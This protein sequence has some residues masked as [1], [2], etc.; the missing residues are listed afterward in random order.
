MDKVQ[1]SLDGFQKSLNTPKKQNGVKMAPAPAIAQQGEDVVDIKSNGNKKKKVALAATLLAL[2]AAGTGIYFAVKKG[3]LNIDAVKNFFAKKEIPQPAPKEP[4][5]V[6]DE[7]GGG[8]KDAAQS[9]LKDA[10]RIGDEAAEQAAQTGKK[11]ASSLPQDAGFALG[12]FGLG[13]VAKGLREARESEDAQIEEL[14]DLLKQKADFIEND[15]IPLIEQEGS[16]YY[17]NYSQGII[18]AIEKMKPSVEF[19]ENTAK[20]VCTLYENIVS[21]APGE[22]ITRN[23]TLE[24]NPDTGADVLTVL[25]QG[26][27]PSAVAVFDKD[28]AL[29]QLEI[30]NSSKHETPAVKSR[31]LRDTIGK[32]Y[33]S[34]LVKYNPSTGKVAGTLTF[35][36]NNQVKSY[37]ARDREGKLSKVFFIE[38][39]SQELESVV[40]PNPAGTKCARRYYYDQQGSVSSVDVRPSADLPERKY[41]F[42]EDELAGLELMDKKGLKPLFYLPLDCED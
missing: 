42:R 24:T 4:A 33:M 1:L 35:D 2:G 28:G 25:T 27:I 9:A 23:Y 30:Y 37:L 22:S 17:D 32:T 14:K 20:Q 5:R 41:Y 40:V 31:F 3:K 18:P 26:N 36:E 10:A 15:E 34:H 11:E 39:N 8:I 19:V 7:T 38:P 13:L 6:L 21:G 29:V 16:Q 12:A